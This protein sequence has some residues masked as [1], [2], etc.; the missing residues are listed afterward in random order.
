MRGHKLY[1]PGPEE[2]EPLQP[3]PDLAGTPVDD[4]QGR[5]TGVLHGSLA[6]ADSGLIRYLDVALDEERR[7]V[8]VPMGHVRLER[9]HFGRPRLR[10]LGA[11]R[12]EL[13]TVPTYHADQ[14]EV[15]GRLGRELAQAHGRLFHGE[16]YYAHPAFDHSGLYAGEHPIVQGPLPPP[17]GQPL[18]RRGDLPEY[19]L[20]GDEPDIRG[21][22]LEAG[23]RSVGTID[24]LVVD[25]E[26][27]K[28]RYAIVSL[29][30]RDQ[31][32]LLPV[33]YLRIR[34][35]ERRIE[36]PALQED[37]L[38]A[39]PRY[40]G[41]PITRAVEEFV[42]DTL[43]ERLDGDGRHFRR[44]DYEPAGRRTHRT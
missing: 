31:T 33:G 3:V 37:D 39:L 34:E 28:V 44:P 41:G 14:Q 5:P 16:R 19:Q 23:G 13:N 25:T 6:E 22:P 10:L 15:D 7:H 38:I 35:G 9:E 18:H 20:A 17:R 42:R 30:G 29:E 40:E 4:A 11:T 43:E 26:A 32:I 1:G 36:A 24:D 27:N 2:V 21:W 8:L 12:E